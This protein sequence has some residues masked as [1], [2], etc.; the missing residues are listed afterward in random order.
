MDDTV[1]ET[2]I[3]PI[4]EENWM[5]HIKSLHS[6]EPLNSDQK[7][8]TNRLQNLEQERRL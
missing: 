5:S 3:P 6:S 2:S 7:I 4:T 1:K 8:I